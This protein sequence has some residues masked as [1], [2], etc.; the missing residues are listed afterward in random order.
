MEK[1]GNMLVMRLME[2]PLFMEII[3]LGYKLSPLYLIILL[4]YY[5]LRENVN[6]NPFFDSTMFI[7]TIVEWVSL[8]VLSSVCIYAVPDFLQYSIAEVIGIIITFVVTF[9]LEIIGGYIMIYILK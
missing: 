9:S 3:N 5:L 7:L 1:G 6:R 8:L 2:M 4:V